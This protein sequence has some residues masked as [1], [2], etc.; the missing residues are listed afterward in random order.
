MSF[1]DTISDMLTRIRNVLRNRG[2]RVN[3]RNS[4]I[5]AGVAQVL[6]EEG[7]IAD[8][9]VIDDGRQGVLRIDLRYAKT[10]EPAISSL[11]RVSKPSC[12]VY[13][14]SQS[15]PRPLDGL[16]IAIVSTSR[17]VLSDRRAREQRVG[18]ELLCTVE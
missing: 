16:G 9:A 8:Y 7:Y 4:K 3:C 17:G 10:G 11:K 12:R 13:S 5:C 14:G 1:N 18:G 2:E 6:K 15:L